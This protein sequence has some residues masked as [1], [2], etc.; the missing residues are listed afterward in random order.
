MYPSEALTN[1]NL[2]G[3]K[4]EFDGVVLWWAQRHHHYAGP[5]QR[6]F[7]LICGGGGW[8]TRQYIFNDGA[9]RNSSAR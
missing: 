8:D 6:L 4:V 5:E 9:K 2:L 1:T 7:D 3:I